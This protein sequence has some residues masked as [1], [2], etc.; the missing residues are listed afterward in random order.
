MKPLKIL[1]IVYSLA[2]SGGEIAS[3]AL[4]DGMLALGV[5]THI[6]YFHDSIEQDIN[7]NLKC[8]LV[9]IKSYRLLPKKYRYQVFAKMV[10]RYIKAKIGRLDLIISNLNQCNITMSYSKL[11]RQLYVIHSTFSKAHNIDISQL[12]TDENSLPSEI[13]EQLSYVDKN[14][15]T[16]YRKI[17]AKHPCICVSHGVE[18]DFKRFFGDITQTQTI[19]NAFDQK[20]I[21]QAAMEFVPSEDNYII[22]VGSFYP[23]KAHKYLL[24]AYAKSSQRY[25]LMLIG[26]GKLEAEIRALAISLGVEEK[27]IFKGYQ[28]NPFPYIKHAQGLVLASHYEGLGRV[29]V[30]AQALAVPAISTDCPSGP[31]ELLPSRCLVPVADIDALS[32]KLTDLMNDPKKYISSFN[33]DLLPTNIARQY[34]QFI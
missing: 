32:N 15:V 28:Y 10:D 21:E 24:M 6:L 25:P 14:I 12:A 3:L 33:S 20:K 9:D 13:F 34:L 5:E 30:E 31:S 19:Y 16:Y 17:Y 2:G 29:L 4:A 23:V 26:K 27:V 22:H 11:E 7:P 18:K 1:I 8:H